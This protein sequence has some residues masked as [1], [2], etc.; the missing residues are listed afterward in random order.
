LRAKRDIGRLCKAYNAAHL[1]S[2]RAGDRLAGRLV[3]VR[4]EDV[5]ADGAAT[6]APVWA[7]CGIAP[8]DLTKIEDERRT[9]HFE[10]V[11]DH[12]Y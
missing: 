11:A 1:P 4:Y 7:R 3:Y 12:R 5:V 8:G 10:E 6:M 9:S 2:L